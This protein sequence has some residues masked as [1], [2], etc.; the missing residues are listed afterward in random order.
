MPEE[1]YVDEAGQQIRQSGQQSVKQ[2][3]YSSIID[4]RSDDL[5][6]W[7]L[8]TP[9]KID[10]FV[11]TLAGK[12][13]DPETG[14]LKANPQYQVFNEK[15]CVFLKGFLK[16][17]LG[18][19]MFMTR[20]DDEE[21]IRKMIEPL[22][23]HLSIHFPLMQGEYEIEPTVVPLLLHTLTNSM[24]ATMNRGLGQGERKWLGKQATFETRTIEQPKKHNFLAGL[25]KGGK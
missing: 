25:F 2:D 12:T 11:D 3:Y 19:H 5:I 16:V 7:I 17:N 9:E 6:K 22:G 23:A 1:Y 18:A 14:E 15:C 20:Y 8:D 21:K 10:S 24:I 4:N 13:I